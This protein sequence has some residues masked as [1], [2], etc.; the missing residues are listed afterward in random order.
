MDGS[1]LEERSS[2]KML[3][4]TLSYTISIAK[5]AS[6]KIGDLIYFMKFLSPEVSLYL[7]KSTIRPCIEYCCH[8]WA[9][10]PLCYL[11]LLDNKKEWICRT[12]GPSLAT[13]L[14]LLAHCQNAASLSLCYKFTLL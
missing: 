11:E 8:V 5:T 6:R 13:C 12:F 14:E 4:L 3:G 7:Y 10:F 9:G 1:V 2:L